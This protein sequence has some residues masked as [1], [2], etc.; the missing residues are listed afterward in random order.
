MNDHQTTLQLKEH[1]P[2]V[3]RI[4]Y[5]MSAKLPQSIELDDLIQA[6]MIGLLDAINKYEVQDETQFTTYAS[7]RIRGAMLDD[8]RTLDWQS[9]A[10]RK[11]NRLI[12]EAISQ[13]QHTLCRPPKESELAKHMG[14]SLPEYQK[15]LQ[16][17]KNKLINYE[18]YHGDDEDN[19]EHF[20]D[21]N[22]SDHNDPLSLLLNDDLRTHVI[23]AIN[24]LPDREKTLMG[25][26]YE[27]E[28][29]LKEIGSIMGVT[30]SRVCQ[31]HTQAVARLRSSLAKKSWTSLA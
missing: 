21:R 2:L 7:K 27:Q 26:Y 22:F 14:V 15:I 10:Q 6:G 3:R 4:A 1:A 5:H 24:D 20:L 9:R 8:L 11:N 18:D 29:N 17:T 23:D 16:D 28:L 19:D 30:E 13:L 25:L 12:E 31:L